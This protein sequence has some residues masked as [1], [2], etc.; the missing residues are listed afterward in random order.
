MEHPL[1][2]HARTRLSQH[3][4]SGPT[5]RNAEK[6]I[7]N[8]S[9]QQTRTQNDVASWEN[10]SFRRRYKH[11]LLHLLAE[12]ERSPVVEVALVVCEG[13]VKLKLKFTPQLVHRITRKE[14]DVKG[15][16]KYTPDVLWPDGPY[17]HAMFKARERDL[18][19]EKAKAAEA[20]YEGLFK[21]GKCKSTKTT[22]YQMQTRSADEPM[23]T[24]VTCKGC[25][26]RWKC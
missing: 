8:W 25:G 20:D 12:L 17:S 21:C 16:A 10:H 14:L 15:L 4:A 1:R 2:D 6:S 7:Y 3:F 9:V 11:K 19:L 22:Y 26:N 24:Y 23:T 13:A 5:V 18:A